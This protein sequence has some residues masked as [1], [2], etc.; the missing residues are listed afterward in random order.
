MSEKDDIKKIDKKLYFKNRKKYHVENGK[1]ILDPDDWGDALWF[2]EDQPEILTCMENF[3]DKIKQ[4]AEQTGTT[5]KDSIETFYNQQL[6]ED[7]KL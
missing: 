7:Q 1:V 2:Y 3:E 4:L 6:N 5:I